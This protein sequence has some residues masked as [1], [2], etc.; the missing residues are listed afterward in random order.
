MSKRLQGNGLWASSR[1]FLPEHKDRNIQHTK[2]FNL[3]TKPILD[4]QKMEE[5]GQLI[6]SAFEERRE[7]TLTLFH[8]KTDREATGCI[9]KI[10]TFNQRLRIE[11]EWVQLSNIVDC[12]SG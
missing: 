1:M 2:M 5:I 7:I 12:R 8:Q 4:E 6:S 9:E 10:D 3:K 11:G